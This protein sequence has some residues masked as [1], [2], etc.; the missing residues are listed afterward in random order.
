MALVSSTGAVMSIDATEDRLLET[1]LETS[2]GVEGGVDAGAGRPKKLP[3][4]I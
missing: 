3:I 4:R 2:L 1:P